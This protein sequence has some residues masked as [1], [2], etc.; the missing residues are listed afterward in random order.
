MADGETLPI[1]FYVPM[2]TEGL[3]LVAESDGEVIG[4][5]AN[6]ACEDALHLW[7]LE[8]RRDRQGRG[9]GRALVQASVELARGRKLPAVTLTTFN[10]VSWN[11]P[12]YAHLGFEM[13]DLTTLNP[14]LAAIRER[15]ASLGFPMP[16]RCAMRL[17]L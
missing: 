14:R 15:E 2:Q 4:F 17:V 9:V 6:Q 5:A 11:G 1:E 16:S 7:E 12:F 3:V 10:D 8:V 13:L